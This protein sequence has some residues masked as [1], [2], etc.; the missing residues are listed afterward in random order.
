V[1]SDGVIRTVAGNGISG[2]SGD[3]DQAVLAQ[4]NPSG[5]A[6]DPSGNLYIAEMGNNCIRKVTTD[7]RI[8]TILTELNEPFDIEWGPER[9]LYIA[10]RNGNRILK[11]RDYSTTI[12]T[13]YFPEVVAGDGWSTLFTITNTGSTEAT[14]VLDFRDPEGSPLAVNAELMNPTETTL[15]GSSSS[16]FAL[17]IPA[18]GAIFL[19]VLFSGNPVEMQRVGRS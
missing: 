16:S 1:G 9:N 13:M 17:T 12:T 8:G 14:G 5:I 18:R 2:H 15:S 7:G 4:I 11:T 10:E 3:G 19:S 6:I